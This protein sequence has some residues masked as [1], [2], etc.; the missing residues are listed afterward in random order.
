MFM[1]WQNAGVHLLLLGVMGTVASGCKPTTEGRKAHMQERT[2]LVTMKGNPVTLLGN[3]VKVGQKAPD[4]ELVANDLA[5]V[6]LSSLWQRKVCILLAVPSLDTPVCDQETKRFNEE[7]GKMGDG[8]VILTVSMDLPFAQKRW[9]GAAG[10]E[11]VITLS[12]YQEAAF[13]MSYG[14]LIKDLRLLA[15]TVFV[16]DKQGT[17]RYIE[18]VKEIGSEPNYGAALNAAR[19]LM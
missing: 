18:L 9:C 2:G 6:K 12:D 5:K 4:V 11:N 8:V 1:W 3:E 19:E 17:I 7:A 16:V 14:V 10:V 15:R 13:G